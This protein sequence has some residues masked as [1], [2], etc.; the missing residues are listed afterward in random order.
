MQTEDREILV[1]L[2]FSVPEELNR[3]WEGSN[4]TITISWS[5]RRDNRWMAWYRNAPASP[6]G[7]NT[8]KEALEELNNCFPSR[9]PIGHGR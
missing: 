2:G 4:E 5:F 1:N 9:P 3:Y 6:Q 8:L 7:G